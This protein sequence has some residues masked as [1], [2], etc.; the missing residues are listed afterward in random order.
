MVEF[1][2]AELAEEAQAQVERIT[3]EKE[4]WENKYEQKRKAL[5]EY[6]QAYTRTTAD[7][8]RK[9][10]ALQ[11][12]LERLEAE[13]R[14]REEQHSEQVS[15]LQEQ[16]QTLDSSAG[17][18][19]YFGSAAHAEDVLKLRAQAQDAE[20][21]LSDL[22][23]AYDRD[24]ALWEGKCQF[25]EQQKETYKRD[26][27][28]SQ[29]KFEVTLEQLQKRGSLDKDKQE[30]S[31]KALMAV[32]DSKYQA[33]IRD[34]MDSHTVVVNE[35]VAKARRLE[36]EVK[37]L[38][39]RLLKEQAL[40]PTSE[41]GAADRRRLLELQESEKRLQQEVDELKQE[42]D[43]RVQDLHRQLDRE[44]ETQ[45][46]RLQEQEAKAKEAEKARSQN[47][48]EY[49][50][51]RARWQLERDGLLCKAQELEDQVE[52]LLLQKETLIK[53]NTRVKADAKSTKQR[54]PS[55]A[56]ATV[57]GAGPVQQFHHMLVPGSTRYGKPVSL[58]GS[59]QSFTAKENSR[60]LLTSQSVI[61]EDPKPLGLTKNYS[62]YANGLQGGTGGNGAPL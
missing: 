38:T 41:Q 62:R 1:F 10:A 28:E 19:F 34:L 8:E 39:E 55:F 4:L 33:R 45:R 17:A 7:L 14:Q 52:K 6:E 15:L 16:L 35:S 60:P 53:E 32:L 18:A 43:R 47:M 22:Q 24:K 50:K 36:A 13:R 27:L 30:S 59:S 26:L 58:T 51:E 42:G 23:C 11:Q 56:A 20:R 3:S 29:R 48:F 46:A 37:A 9:V 12:Q 2:R 40:K 49:E 44:R 61:I 25:L 57:S 21:E 5:K 31:Q 54:Q